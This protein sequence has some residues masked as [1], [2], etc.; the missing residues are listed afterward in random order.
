MDEKDNPESRFQAEM[1]RK[2]DLIIQKLGSHDAR[3]DSY[4]TRFDNLERDVTEIKS[5]VKVLKGQFSEVTK[6]VIKDS[7]RITKLESEVAELQS[8]IH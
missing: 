5:D 1:T 8:N 3:F 6:V 7:Q 4:D 2:I